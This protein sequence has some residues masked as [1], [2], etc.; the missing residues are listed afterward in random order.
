MKNLLIL[1]GGLAIGYML[2]TH[3]TTKRVQKCMKPDAIIIDTDE[4]IDDLAEQA[5]NTIK[6]LDKS[7]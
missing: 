2:Y 4:I 6:I 5:K 7:D 1:L 3:P